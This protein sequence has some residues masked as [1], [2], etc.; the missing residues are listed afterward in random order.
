MALYRQALRHR[1]AIAGDR[2]DLDDNERL[3]FLGDAVLDTVVGQFVYQHYPEQGEGFL[4]RMRSKLVSRH[5]LSILAK[6]VEIERVMEV[7]IGPG[8]HTSV[9]GNAMEA[10]VGALF[11]DKGFDRTRAIV[12]KLITTHFDLKEVEQEDRDSKSRL[13]EW[14][15]KKRRKV[16]FVLTEEQVHG[17]G[18]QFVA[19]VQVDGRNTGRGMGHSKKRAEQEAA[20]DASRKLRLPNAG[21]NEGGPVHGESGKASAPRTHRRRKPKQDGPAGEA[22]LKA[23]PTAGKAHHD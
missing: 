16:V 13:L 23:K 7:K 9:P 2:P 8:Q 11:L 3:E 20:R 17:R 5:Q 12:I 6:K 22:V 19:E 21:S 10:L 1:S 18:K 15:Q 14:G 4:T